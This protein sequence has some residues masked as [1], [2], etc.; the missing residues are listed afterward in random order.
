MELSADLSKDALAEIFPPQ[1]LRFYPALVSTEADALAWARAGAPEGALVVAGYQ[2]SPR[3]RSGIYWKVDGQND[4][5]FSLI[6]RPMFPVKRAGWLYTV[7]ISGLADAL[8]DEARIEWPDEVYIG[9]ERAGAV[10]VQMGPGEVSM[11]WAVINIHVAGASRPRGQ[12]LKRIVDAV[13][14]RYRSANEVVLG[15][16]LARCRTLGRQVVARLIPLGTA[17]PTVS[18]KAVGSLPDGGLVI[19][20]EKG[21]RIVVLP[22][23]LGILESPGETL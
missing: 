22:Q 7:S 3:G 11:D 12:Q 15:D 4:L 8:G 6:V 5:A 23:N 1:L 21:S 10:G 18:G 20:T 14:V 13:R 9:Q 2:A 16:Y 19:L 17:G